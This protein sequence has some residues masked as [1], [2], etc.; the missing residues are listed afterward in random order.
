MLFEDGIFNSKLLI[1]QGIFIKHHYNIFKKYSPKAIVSTHPIVTVNFVVVLLNLM[2]LL[3]LCA[4]CSHVN[5]QDPFLKCSCIGIEEDTGLE[6]PPQEK[7]GLQGG[8]EP[9]CSALLCVNCSARKSCLFHLEFGTT[10]F[11][12]ASATN[13]GELWGWGSGGTTWAA[14]HQDGDWT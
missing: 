5:M 7:W 12:S 8:G 13:G 2:T 4:A 1:N 14:G 11:V 6:L 10:C 3:F 9:L